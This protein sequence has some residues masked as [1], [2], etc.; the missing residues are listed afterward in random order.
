MPEVGLWRLLMYTPNAAFVAH[1]LRPSNR[2]TE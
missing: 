1:E 2:L